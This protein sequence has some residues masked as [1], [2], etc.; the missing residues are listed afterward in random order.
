MIRRKTPR[1]SRR[2][3]PKTEEEDPET[4]LNV[5]S[6][7][8]ES[9]INV[10]EDEDTNSS[11]LDERRRSASS[12]SSSVTLHHQQQLQ[13]HH[14]TGNSITEYKPRQLHM[15]FESPQEL[16]NQNNDPAYL[17]VTQQ[18]HS[19][20]SSPQYCNFPSNS[21]NHQI[22]PLPIT[23]DGSEVDNNEMN[24]DP[25][26]LLLMQQTITQD[27]E[28]LRSQIVQLRR[29]YLRMYKI[30]T[31]EVNKAFNLIDVQRS[32]IEFL[33]N[34]LRNNHNQH[35][36]QMRIRQHEPVPFIDTNTNNYFSN[37]QAQPPPPPPEYNNNNTTTNTTA[38]NNS[39]LQHHST[40]P[41]TP[42]Y[43]QDT[44]VQQSPLNNRVVQGGY[45]F[46]FN[47]SNDDGLKLSSPCSSVVPEKWIPTP[48]A[49][50]HNTQIS[51]LSSAVI[52]ASTT[53][54]S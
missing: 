25:H 18:Q 30:L 10:M 3:R 11:S 2:K 9:E 50:H 54:D 6:G 41:S 14:Q 35:Q 42:I 17:Q 15:I 46:L 12:T 26:D 39:I 45:E 38:A 37:P 29:G 4:I 23:A 13:Q 1:Y 34:M 5:G 27:E 40:A 22:S 7:D 19:S 49:F 21:M 52:S 28:Q 32:R 31:G 36:Q 33:E 47:N 16:M 24:N 43:P 53:T 48:P 44:F 20:S 8:D 51:G